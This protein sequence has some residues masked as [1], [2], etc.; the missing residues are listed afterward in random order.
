M[1]KILLERAE[2]MRSNPT[3]AEKIFK[4]KLDALKIKYK[5]QYIIGS[6]IVDFLVGN[7]IY[8]IDG[9][10]HIGKEEYDKIRTKYL[11]AKGYKVIRVLNKDVETFKI[12][13]TH[14]KKPKKQ[15]TDI[16]SG[17]AEFKKLAWNKQRRILQRE[18]LYGY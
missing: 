15:I 5:F 11:S 2:K 18:R 8:E 13:T 1:E 6:Y 12:Q 16:K 7:T 3:I 4:E 9:S 10:S 17:T 14:K